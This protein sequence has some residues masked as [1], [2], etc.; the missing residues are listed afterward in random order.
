MV[1]EDQ[2][3]HHGQG[4][5]RP[6]GF[7]PRLLALHTRIAAV[8]TGLLVLLV[9]EQPVG[10][11]IQGVVVVADG[12]KEVAVGVFQVGAIGGLLHVTGV[13]RGGAS[14]RLPQAVPGCS[15]GRDVELHAVLPGTPGCIPHAKREGIGT[16]LPVPAAVVVGLVVVVVRCRRFDHGV[17]AAEVLVV[18]GV[19][20]VDRLPHARTVALLDGCAYV[21]L[22]RI[23]GV[24][25]PFILQKIGDL[26]HHRGGRFD[27]PF[28]LSKLRHVAR[29]CELLHVQRLACSHT[30]QRKR[31]QRQLPSNHLMRPLFWLTNEAQPL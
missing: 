27:A 5:W 25:S 29:G 1:L 10:F 22:R 6:L 8:L 12:E 23:K 26:I 2:K 9:G 31:R 11:G 18:K 16:L 15:G 3:T 30:R 21:H 28:G 20:G 24:E 7:A 14:E 13:V 17:A 19:N 4:H